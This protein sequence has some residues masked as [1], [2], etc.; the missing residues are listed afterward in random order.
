MLCALSFIFYFSI[1]GITGLTAGALAT[2]VHVHDTYFIVGH[3]HYVMFGGTGFAFLGALHYWFPKMFGRRYDERTARVGWAIFFVGFFVLYSPMFSLGL[4]GMPRRYYTYPPEF[5]ALHAVSTVGSWI[6]AF[7]LAL[8]F[9]NL[10]RALR[11]GKTAGSNPW[12]GTTLEWTVPSPPPAEDFP[13]I[14]T[15][16]EAPYG[17]GE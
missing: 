17:Y 3:F 16:T 13:E 1:G 2:D 15:V 11:S 6:L 12:G 14:P 10:A 5:H 7:G 4:H 8:M 9:W